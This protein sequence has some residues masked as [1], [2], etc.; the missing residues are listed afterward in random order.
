MP[1][2]PSPSVTFV[3]G[4]GTELWD[5]TGKRHL[6]FLSGLAVVS[7]GHANPVVADAVAEQA[8]T[9]CHVSNLFG[10]EVG[11]AVARQLDELL[12]TGNPAASRYQTFFCNSGAESN[13]AAIKLARKFGGRGKHDV[14][15]AFSS[16]HGRTLATL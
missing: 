8:R 13:E 16:F 3:R 7:L 4:A 6:D 5:D 10:T 14:V 9:L 11:P 1:T 15:C 2:Y 12:R